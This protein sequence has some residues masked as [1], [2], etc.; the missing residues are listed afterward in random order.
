MIAATRQGTPVE[1]VNEREAMARAAA[2][3]SAGDFQDAERLARAIVRSNPRHFYALHLLATLAARHGDWPQCM[4]IAT[5]A[6]AVDPSNVEVLS[7]RGAALRMLDRYDEAIADYDRA[8]RLAPNHADA[9]NNRGVALAALNRHA[10]AVES[11]GRA[12]A[13]R[14]D[15]PRARFNRALS[16]L[17]AGDFER[18]WEDYEARWE[19]SKTSAP[20]RAYREPEWDGRTPLAGR[21]ILLYGEQGLGDAI[22][23]ARYVPAV[24]SLGARVI[25]EVHLPLK[26]LIAPLAGAENTFAF[27]EALP[28]FDCHRAL[29][30]LPHAFGT[31]LATIPAAIPYLEAPPAHVERWRTRLGNAAHPRIGIAWSGSPTPDPHRSIPLAA[32]APLRALGPTLVSLQKDVRPDDRAAVSADPPILH[33]GDELA[34]FRDTA[35][36]ASLMDL[37]ISVDT[38]AAHVAGALGRPMWLLLPFSP[39]WRWLLERADSPWYPTARLF[40]QPHIGDWEAIIA[41]VAAA[42]RSP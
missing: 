29:M 27:G 26:P 35:A 6:L 3:F 7:N 14:P 21:T 39:D 5:R 22:Q 31:R 28:P 25:L 40:R 19:G 4:Q 11:Y 34:D 9:F 1:V 30:S 36:L 32:W 42:L 13:L 12:L 33:F 38:S 18:G 20:R 16:R 24:R 8:L 37:V 10:E 23:F 2:S 15:S 17:V 41:R